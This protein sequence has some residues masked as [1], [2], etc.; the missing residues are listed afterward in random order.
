MTRTIDLISPG[1]FVV[2]ANYWASHAGTAMWRDWRPEQ[3]D[4]DLRRLAAHGLE[5]LRVFPLWP[6]FQP[7]RLLR[8]GHNHPTEY[9]HGEE[10]LPDDPIGQAGLSELMLGRFAT[11]A[12]LAEQ[13]GLRLIVGLLT[14]WMSGRM[15][16][17]PAF[18][19]AN[20][21]TDPG[22]IRW[23]IRLI[24]EFVGRFREHPAIAAW[25]L[26]NECNCMGPAN[27]DQA[28]AWTAIVADA[29]RVADPSR[30]VVSGMHSLSPTG[31]WTMQ[32][33]AELTDLLTT[34]P[35]PVFTPHCDHDP[36][37]SIRTIL[38]GTAESRY[39]A[40][41]GGKPCLCQEIG[42]LGPVIASETIGADFLRACLVSLWAN[43][44]HGLLWW[45]AH[46][47]D[48]LTHAPYDWHAVERELGLLRQDGTAKPVLEALR[49]FREFREGLPWERLPVR[50]RQAICVLSEGQ[51]QWAAALGSFVLAKQAGFDLEF[52]FGAQPIREAPV[53]LLPSLCGHAMLSRRR[54]S[55]LL[56][57]VEAGADLY[58]SL[59]SGLPS[60]FEEITG[61]EPQRRFRRQGPAR[62]AGRGL[63][64]LTLPAEFAVEFAVTRATVLAEEDSGNPA[65]TVAPYGAGRV[66]FLG[67]P[68][69][70]A[71]ATTPGVLHGASAQPCWE[72][73]RIIGQRALAARR[74]S[75]DCPSLALTEHPSADG[76]A[77]AVAINQSAEACACSLAVAAGWELSEV[78]LGEARSAPGAITLELGPCRASVIRLARTNAETTGGQG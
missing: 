18:E 5:V 7:L 56:A 10:P 15:H 77:I 48:H 23:E 14:G 38:H 34:H 16:L 72:V 71:T 2:G 47:Q 13:H 40:D 33:Q 20:P 35:Y 50:E 45:C 22:A 39:Y 62:L 75:K 24:R 74:L 8:S 51:D 31:D 66:F 30:P 76:S 68:L 3:V 55:E 52:Q 36:V 57:R 59:G 1:S 28:Y 67:A 44:C 65:L 73:Y 25:D 21:L 27:R 63:R 61:L 43:D 54:M 4:E 6:D 29:I 32:D 41:I 42:T 60:G 58:L 46:D 64:E 11:F 69:E 26:G 49:G 19:S 37:D 78:L 53:Y 70:L 9:R 17:P 12:D